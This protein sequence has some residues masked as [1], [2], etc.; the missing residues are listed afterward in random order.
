MGPSTWA[1]CGR[2]G[3]WGAAQQTPAGPARLGPEIRGSRWAAEPGRAGYGLCGGSG[4][5]PSGAV[6]QSLGACFGPRGVEGPRTFG[7]AVQ[8]RL[9]W[10]GRDDIWTVRQMPALMGLRSADPIPVG[11]ESVPSGPRSPKGILVSELAPKHQQVPEARPW[12]RGAGGGGGRAQGLKMSTMELPKTARMKTEVCP[13]PPGPGTRA[14]AG[15]AH[16]TRPRGGTSP[17][18]SP[19]SSPHPNLAGSVS[20]SRVGDRGPVVGRQWAPRPLVDEALGS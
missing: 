11:K 2:E 19:W 13:A 1:G 6:T 3:S 8:F 12:A 5:G 9:F 17:A 15:S 18:G 20:A 14:S 7:V 4:P 10:R 16:L